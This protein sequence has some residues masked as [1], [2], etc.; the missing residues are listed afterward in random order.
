MNQDMKFST[1]YL[2]CL[3][4]DYLKNYQLVNQSQMP[5]FTIREQVM[6]IELDLFEM[7]YKKNN[8]V[9]IKEFYNYMGFCSCRGS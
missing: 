6:C 4:S 2:N 3:S 9:T 1:Q 8:Q 7:V 5:I